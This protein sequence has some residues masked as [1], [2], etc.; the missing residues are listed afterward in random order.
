MQLLDHP[1]KPTGDLVE[2]RATHKFLFQDLFDWAG[3]LRTVDIRKNAEGSE[4]FLPVSLI[5][6][7]SS[8]TTE[9]VRADDELRGMNRDQIVER[10]AYHY[11]QLN[12][13]PLP[14]GQRPY[15]ASV[16]EPH[17]P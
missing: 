10:L 16:L 3:R 9:E 17:R 8:F 12:S 11:D 6:R 1:P 14:R 7:A 2:F 15:P 4:F 13:P 5:E